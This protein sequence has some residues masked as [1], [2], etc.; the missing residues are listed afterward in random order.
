MRDLSVD[1]GFRLIFYPVDKNL[2]DDAERIIVKKVVLNN[3]T[4]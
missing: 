2:F 3:S 4:Y 1:S